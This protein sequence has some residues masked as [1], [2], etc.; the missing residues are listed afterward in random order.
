MY[1]PGAV[2]SHQVANRDSNSPAAPAPS[3]PCS[4]SIR[5]IFPV[6]VTSFEEP[7]VFAYRVDLRMSVRL[8]LAL[9]LARS[10]VLSRH[11][12]YESLSH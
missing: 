12:W 1:I 5:V 7:C 6:S 10:I 3:L 2:K 4:S 9:A 8:A 11:I